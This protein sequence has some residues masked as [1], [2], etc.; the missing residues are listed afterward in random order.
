METIDISIPTDWL[1][2]QRPSPAELREAIRLGL[3]QLRR[4][5]TEQRQ[6]RIRVQQALVEAGLAQPQSETA[7]SDPL[8]PERR[9]KLAKQAAAGGP[10]SEVIIADRADRI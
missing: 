10:L 3:A 9:R 6:H 5:Q 8:T 2:E 4:Q 7:A 1:P